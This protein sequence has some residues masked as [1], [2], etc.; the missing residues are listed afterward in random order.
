[1]KRPKVSV[2][3]P[4]YN[5]EKYLNRCIDSV[6]AQTFSDFELLLI[7]DGSKDRS[8]EICDE[9]SK[10]DRRICIFHKKN[11]GVSS[12]RNLGLDRAKGVWIAFIDSDDYV[13][14]SYIENLISAVKSENQVVIGGYNIVGKDLHYIIEQISLSGS[15][16]IEYIFKSKMIYWSQPWARLYNLKVINNNK[17]RFPVGVNLGED[18]IF[19]INYYCVIDHYTQI[20]M[21]DY[22]YE[23][24]NNDSLTHKIFSFDS[25]YR[26][27]ILW[28]DS[29]SQLI[30]RYNIFY[31]TDEVLWSYGLG[32]QFVRCLRSIY[33]R[34]NRYSI[35]NQIRY[36]CDI[37]CKTYDDFCRY[38]S[39]NTGKQEINQYLISKRLFWLFIIFN[40]FWKNYC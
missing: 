30:N 25:E 38:F 21:A 39:C 18:A 4:V 31:N 23:C 34:R 2:I 29:L 10:K 37:N 15:D 33:D 8:G 14:K 20:K 6:L 24:S 19:N 40:K 7:D 28:K 27:F 12:A 1:M 13:N 9:Y 32:R 26:T 36:L 22:N 5:A 11:E 16:F 35:S 3:I 17:I